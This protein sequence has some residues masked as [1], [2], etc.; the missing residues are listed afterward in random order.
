MDVSD[1]LQNLRAGLSQDG[2]E[3]DTLG[4][5]EIA[6]AEA[7]NNII[8]HGHPTC[9]AQ[10]MYLTARVSDQEIR[11]QIRDTGAP[12]PDSQLNSANLPDNSGPRQSLPEGGFGWYLIHKMVDGLNYH[13]EAGEN[14]LELVFS[15]A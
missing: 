15:R 11:I 6:L 8:E 3:A 14:H 7:L 13:Q 10:T 9:D 2:V 1:T 5:M 12:V 4:R